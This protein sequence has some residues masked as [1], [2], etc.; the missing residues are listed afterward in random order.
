MTNGT[1]KSTGGSGKHMTL[2]VN[3]PGGMQVIAVPADVLVTSIAPTEQPLAAGQR[4]F[5]QA[6][7]AADGS[8]VAQRVMLASQPASK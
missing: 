5:V 3:Y 2:T 6:Q 4:V 8:L 1:V 7:Q